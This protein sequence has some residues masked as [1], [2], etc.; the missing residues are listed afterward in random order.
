MIY[1]I[2]NG[3]SLAH[4]FDLEGEIIVC[5]ECLID[6]DLRAKDLNKLWNVR[7]EFI[8]RQYGADDYFEKVKGEFDKLTKIKPTDE[9]NLWF[10]DDAF[11]QVNM[12]FVLWMIWDKKP[13]FYRV[14][15][16]SK[17]WNCTFDE[18][19]KCFNDRKKLSLE[20]VRIGELI[21]QAFQSKDSVNLLNLSNLTF[22]NFPKTKEV[23]QAL[24][25]IESKPKEILREITANGETNFS[26]I[27]TQFKEKA[28][29]YGFG[30]SQVKNILAEI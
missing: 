13:T 3:D 18:L 6:G 8:K 19:G 30:D 1:H 10:G 9:V 12:F 15:P 27:F 4:N 22:P 26:K 17:D 23:C 21:W 29:V 11:C 16:D 2:L 28:G 24:I 25:D 20:D 7:A 5:R 14:F